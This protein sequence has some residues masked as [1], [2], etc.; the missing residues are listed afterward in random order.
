MDGLW[1]CLKTLAIS[2]QTLRS[3]DHGVQWEPEGDQS[4]CKR[5]SELRGVIKIPFSPMSE[6]F[7][8][9]GNWL[10]QE[11]EVQTLASI[12]FPGSHRGVG[13]LSPSCLDSMQT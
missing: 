8:V 10:S 11:G 4:N 12:A 9:P 7:G 2:P 3:L 5:I 1:C 6:V 13:P